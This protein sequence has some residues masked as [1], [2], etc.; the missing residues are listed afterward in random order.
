MD[1]VYTGADPAGDKIRLKDRKHLRPQDV[2][3]AAV[4]PQGKENPYEE[5]AA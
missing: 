5:R 2:R 3:T 1:G 4:R